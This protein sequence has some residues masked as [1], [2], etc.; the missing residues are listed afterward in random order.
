MTEL[1]LVAMSVDA[2]ARVDDLLTLAETVGARHAY[3]QNGDP[4]LVDVLD[5]LAA[6]GVQEITLVAAPSGGGAAP[7][8]S[9]L[10]RVAG[11]WLRD[12]DATQ[13]LMVAGRPVSGAEAPLTSSAWEDVPAHSHQLL[14]C[15]GPR[16]AARG[17]ADTASALRGA[18]RD[19]GLGDDDVLLT[20]TGCL[21]PCN[22]AP[23]VVVHPDD[24]WYGPVDADGACSL[25]ETL[26]GASVD[27]PRRLSRGP[28]TASDDGPAPSP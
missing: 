28:R 5:E 2:A 22:H 13:V 6:A 19:H 4:S 9:W 20:Q 1:V 27:L 11:H 8:R 7:A 10:R 21:F 24:A 17:A 3:L 18:L 12:R 15:R 26:A 25:V 16:C 23:V 14:V